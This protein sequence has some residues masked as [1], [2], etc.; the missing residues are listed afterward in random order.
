MLIRDNERNFVEAA[1]ANVEGPHKYL[2]ADEKIKVHFE[3]D[4]RL[5]QLEDTGLSRI[6]LLFEDQ[7]GKGV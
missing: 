3:L 4:E 2:T 6:E 7:A 5:Q 1:H